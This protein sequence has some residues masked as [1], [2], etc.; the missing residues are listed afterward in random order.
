MFITHRSLTSNPLREAINSQYRVDET[1]IIR[2]LLNS[3]KISGK[4]Q[5]AIQRLALKLV[6]RVR[7]EQSRATGLDAFMHE[8]DLSSQEGIQL[9]CLAE[10]LL[11]IP[12]RQTVDKLIADKISHA[13]WEQHVGKSDS[14]FTNASTWALMLTGKILQFNQSAA[15][16]SE[17][18][19]KQVLIELTEKLGEPLI[20]Q[21]I[22]QGMR[23]IARQFVQGTTMTEALQNS[24]IKQEMGYTFSYDMLGEAAYTHDDA[25][26]YF[27]AYRRAICTLGKIDARGDQLFDKPGISIK[28]SAL[29][30]RY[31][32]AQYESV[33]QELLPWLIELTELAEQADIL[34]TID[35]E[36]AKRLE[37][38]LD[39]I[40]ALI[41]RTSQVKWNGLGLAVQAYQ[42]RA[43]AVINW[44]DELSQ[45]YQSCLH[46]RLVKGA[47]WDTE[48]KR[49]QQLGLDGYPVFTRKVNTDVAYLACTQ[50][51][52]ESNRLIF[53]QF[54]THNAQTVASVMQMAGH[55]SFEFQCLHGMGDSL[56]DP[57]LKANKE[58]YSRIYAPVGKHN[59]LL[60]YLVRRLL[61]NGANTSFVN[62]IQNAQ[63]PLEK[64]V[65]DPIQTV[66][67]HQQ[68]PHPRIPLPRDIFKPQRLNSMGLDLTDPTTLKTLRSSLNAF[69]DKFY[70]AS[71]LINTELTESEIIPV[72]NPANH[73][74]QVGEVN[75]ANK[76]VVAT[77]INIAHDA[78]QKWATTDTKER[79]NL[80]GKIASCYE[81]NHA[82]L[83]ALM[84]R[85]T[86]K[87][88]KDASAEVREAV[89]FCR[90]YAYQGLQLLSHSLELNGA[91]GEKNTLSWHPRGVFVCIS[92]W[93]FPLAIFTGQ[94]VAALVTGNTVVAKPATQS[95]LVAHYACCLMY[96]AGVPNDVL[97]LIMGEGSVVGKALVSH[98][99]ISGVV[100]TGG[101]Q[102]AHQIQANL[103][104]RKAAIIPFIAE[105]G[106]INTMIV[107]S[108]ALT[109]QVVADVLESAFNSAGQRCSALR[110]LYLQDDIADKTIRMLIGAMQT[111]VLGNPAMLKTDIGPVINNVA[112]MQLEQHIQVMKRQV[113]FLY[114]CDL[115]A[116]TQKG[117]FIAPALFEI[118]HLSDL[119]GEKFGPV[120]HICRFKGDQLEQLVQEINAAQYGLTLGIHSRINS[121][122]DSL[123]ARLK[124]GNIYIN[125]N[126]I[127]AVVGVQPFGG[128][129]LSG[130]GP[131]AGGPNYLQRFCTERVVS[132]NTTA[133]GGD[134][135]LLSIDDA[136]R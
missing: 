71:C 115:P 39:L 75:Y 98:E 111:L 40:A 11:R 56:Y 18:P 87:T 53:P 23:I 13:D 45:H 133:Q 16:L 80:L 132:V 4:E 113:K 10:S 34:L 99:K 93:N 47:Y 124:V 79:A 32:Y 57:L 44:L 5:A 96:Q 108:S 107:D 122:V 65:E 81:E 68:I 105:T 120:L 121:T 42:K 116:E 136:K 60:P 69:S 29:H 6:K 134:V 30:P 62:R 3:I 14:I 25:R 128:E 90:Y 64:M 52:L 118:Q 28:L 24:L 109:E 88:I 114:Q 63:L 125:R 77:A 85:E 37:L 54:A 27:N 74:E 119:D 55:R 97:Q 130:T 78:S 89:D 127:G 126:Q 43:F 1:T 123:T 100:F 33:F 58:I 135:S 17:R 91:T 8:Y 59:D 86:G 36:E 51:L 61:E 41:K 20:R 38:S 92:P 50:C 110:V 129:G 106:G 104:H 12:D 76:K 46:I 117:T 21:A 49:A 26:R 22:Q 112:M 66:I 73:R 31:V 103:A 19:L 131:K 101:T 83:I 94:I 70:S 102:T 82:E 48:I 84:V 9:M 95:A 72:F 67:H 35:A 15:E 7:K 2:Q